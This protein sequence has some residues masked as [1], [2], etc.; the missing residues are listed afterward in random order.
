MVYQSVQERELH[1]KV[2]YK[3]FVFNFC[4]FFSAA[5]GHTAGPILTSNISY[6]VFL[7]VL[8]SFKG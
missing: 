7:R 2:K 3:T 5:R 4:A 1:E 8:H 6:D